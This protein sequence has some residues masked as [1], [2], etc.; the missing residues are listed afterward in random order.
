M[1]IEIHL[2]QNFA[3]ANLNRG[4]TG[5]PKDCTFG[6][7][8][9]ARISSQCIKRSVRKH[10]TFAQTIKAADQDNE[11]IRTKRLQKEL[12]D[13][14]SD[15]GHEADKA[16]AVA[17]SMIKGIGLDF[18]KKKVQDDED[19]QA[20]NKTQY[21]LY[22]SQSEINA[23]ADLANKHWDTLSSLE[24]AVSEETDKK[25]QKKEGKQALPKDIQKELTDVLRKHP[26]LAADIALFGRMMADDKDMNIDAACQVAH[27]ISTN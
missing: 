4:D 9:R 6:G 18:D 27:E 7:Y 26:R 15:K 21:L 23:L 19:A 25:K 24:T 10:P 2:L 1:F 11:G 8:R 22:L 16:L 20:F 14:L 13:L 12:V 3:P 5:A 17:A